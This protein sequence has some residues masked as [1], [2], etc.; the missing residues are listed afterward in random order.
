MTKTYQRQDN[1]TR[2]NEKA[3]YMSQLDEWANEIVIIPLARAFE[4]YSV[5]ADNGVPQNKAASHV[6]RVVAVVKKAFREKMLESYRNGQA[7]E[8]RGERGIRMQPR[9]GLRFI[10]NLWGIGW[11][12]FIVA[13]VLHRIVL[14]CR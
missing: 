14:G 4:E 8:L 10:W 13:A 2:T 6:D 7:A 9:N 1:P 5:A 11:L 12:G 3:G